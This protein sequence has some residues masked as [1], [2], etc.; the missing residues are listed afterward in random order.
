MDLTPGQRI[1]K[2]CTVP[3]KIL[4]FYSCTD[5]FLCILNL[6]TMSFNYQKR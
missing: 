4:K 1:G 3:W 6:Q 2:T 5:V